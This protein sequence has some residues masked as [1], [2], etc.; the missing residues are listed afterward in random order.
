MPSL[1]LLAPVIW[2]TDHKRERMRPVKAAY[3][4][5]QMKEMPRLIAEHRQTLREGRAKWK[6]ERKFK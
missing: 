2:S 5:E 6:R 3:I 4:E 1:Y